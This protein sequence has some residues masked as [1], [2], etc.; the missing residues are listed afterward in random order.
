MKGRRALPTV[1]ASTVQKHR[2]SGYPSHK[3]ITFLAKNI[4]ICQNCYTIAA[5]SSVITYRGNG[6]S[7]PTPCQQAQTPCLSPYPQ[8]FIPAIQF[9][10]LTAN[11][12]RKF[13]AISEII[14]NYLNLHVLW[15]LPLNSLKLRISEKIIANIIFF[16]VG[17]IR[18]HSDPKT[19]ET[20]K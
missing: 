2:A 1:Q 4:K 9:K 15:N 16:V 17:K 8:S 19:S 20:N 11:P 12:H 10:P 5:P 18:N 7:L 13:L 3:P 14:A 6:H